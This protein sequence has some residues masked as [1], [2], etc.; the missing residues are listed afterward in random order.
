M[1]PHFDAWKQDLLVSA[2][3]ASPYVCRMGDS[4]LDLLWKDGCDST[5]TGLMGYVIQG[6]SKRH[7]IHASQRDSGQS[8]IDVARQ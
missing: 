5:M 7:E 2:G 3:D 1:S 8:P 4:I 6:L